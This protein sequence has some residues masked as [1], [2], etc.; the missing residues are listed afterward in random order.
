MTPYYDEPSIDVMIA[1]VGEDVTVGGV[2]GKGIFDETDE[3]LL[4]A[5]MAHLLGKSISLTVRTSK[6]PG[7]SVGTAVTRAGPPLVNYIVRERLQ[8]G[9]GALT[10]ALCAKA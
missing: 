1:Q 6:F 3:E 9:D 2:A 5:E 8:L 7:L 4:R 10:K